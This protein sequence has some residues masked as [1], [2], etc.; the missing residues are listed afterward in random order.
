MKF[1]HFLCSFTLV[2]SALAVPTTATAQGSAPQAFE[3]SIAIVRVT[4]EDAQGRVVQRTTRAMDWGD[5]D[6]F[7]LRGAG[8]GAVE[9]GVRQA[10]GGARV[11]SSYLPSEGPREV[12]DTHT[13]LGSTIV[14]H[15]D[16]QTRVLVTV[17]SARVRLQ[18]RQAD[19]S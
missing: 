1:I 12:R 9:L 7:E 6:R 13:D 16:E 14:A 10:P 15:A 11:A 18:A 17:R 2:A 3:R 8:G 19:E 5:A 4:L